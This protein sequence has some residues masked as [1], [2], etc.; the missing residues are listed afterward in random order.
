MPGYRVYWLDSKLLERFKAQVVVSEY[1]KARLWWYDWRDPIHV[2]QKI[3]QLLHI[4][5]ET[6][7]EQE[8]PRALTKIVPSMLAMGCLYSTTRYYARGVWRCGDHRVVGREA[9]FGG[10]NRWG[11]YPAAGW[12]ALHCMLRHVHTGVPILQAPLTHV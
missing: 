12:M 5:P 4:V 8:H 10:S 3:W 2:S 11:I 6:P 9:Y 1:A 7:I